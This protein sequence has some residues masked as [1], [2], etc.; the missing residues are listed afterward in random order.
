MN[1]HLQDPKVFAD[2]K[3]KKSVVVPL[4][5]FNKIMLFAVQSLEL[6]RVDVLTSLKSLKSLLLKLMFK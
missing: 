2:A 6:R 1:T 5:S 4:F 3:K